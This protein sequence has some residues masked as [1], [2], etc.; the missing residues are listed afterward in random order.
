MVV[1]SRG[2]MGFVFLPLL[3]GAESGVD[4]IVVFVI[5]NA[6]RKDPESSSE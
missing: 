6:K 4:C 1:V 2:I 5:P 3:R